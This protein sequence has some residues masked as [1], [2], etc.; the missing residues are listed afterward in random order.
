MKNGVYKIEEIKSRLEPVF[1]A[2]GV[3]SAILFGSYAK[4]TADERS[5][6][7]LLVD[8]GRKGLKFVGLIELVRMALDDI[9]VDV[10]DVGYLKKGSRVDNEIHETGVRI[11]G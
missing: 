2:N 3:K 9:E 5:D 4:G 6:V 8:S 11:Y 1:G 7:D 10:I